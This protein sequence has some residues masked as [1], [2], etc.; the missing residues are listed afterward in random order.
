MWVAVIL[1]VVSSCL[2]YYFATKKSKSVWKKNGVHQVSGGGFMDQFLVFIGKKT[3]MDIDDVK[4]NMLEKSGEKYCG[5]VDLVGNCL[6]V[7]DLEILKKILIK[8]FDYFVDRRPFFSGT[9]E[10]LM[11]KM[12]FSLL[13]DEWKGVRTSLTPTFT[14]G[15]IRRM[16]S[17]FNQVGHTWVKHFN[18]KIDE[19]SSSSAKINIQKETIHY[20]VDV[21]ASSVFG[22]NAGTIDDPKSVFA[23]MTLRLQ[24]LSMWKLV[25]FGISMNF[26]W[27]TDFLRLEI[28]DNQAMVFFRDLMVQGL[29]SRMSG[30]S[31]RNDFIQLIAEA[32]RGELKDDDELNDFEKDAQIKGGPGTKKNYLNDDILAQAQLIGFFFAGFS[33]TSNVIAW[34]AYVLAVH[35]D[36]QEKLRKELDEKLFKDTKNDDIDYDQLNEH[37]Y[38]DMFLSEV[39]RKYPPL[40]RLERMCAKDYHDP[41]TGL[42][43]SK[44]SVVVIP[45]QGIHND[46]RYYEHPDKFYPEHFT[47]EKKSERNSYTYLPFGHGPRNCI[48]MR[49]AL[50]EVK[51]A[52]AH[53][54]KNF[55]VEPTEKTPIPMKERPVGLGVQIPDNLELK[56]SRR[57][58]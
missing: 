46:T 11:Q 19:S 40:G 28:V 2:I 34:A 25:K 12:L 58:K 54:V 31:K 36:V 55:K 49:F 6:L 3:M 18:K 30:E 15:K 44:G 42:K 43:I 26:P 52:I 9:R 38:L 20:T 29:S 27:L 41:E 32:R 4:Y 5:F 47:P 16:M 37:V 51:S 56:I 24:E 21:I 23:R 8:D 17:S 35:Q 10:P 39:L 57:N 50:V 53:L 48:G 22:M 1:V 14:T 7:K 45:V 33:T 13:G